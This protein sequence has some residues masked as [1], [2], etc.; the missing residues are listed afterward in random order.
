MSAPSSSPLTD[1]NRIA[2]RC[3][4][5]TTRPGDL[6]ADIEWSRGEDF[7]LDAYHAQ[8]LARAQRN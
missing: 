3:E 6:G 2:E 7:T 4:A 1:A 5:A 8:V